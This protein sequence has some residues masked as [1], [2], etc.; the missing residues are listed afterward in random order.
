M[1]ERKKPQK[2]AR[3]RNLLRF[4]LE[5][6][7]DEPSGLQVR[8]DDTAGPYSRNAAAATGTL[9]RKSSRLFQRS[10]A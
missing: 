4:D 10:E 3:A 1:W 2:W 7:A 6:V 8:G 5:E 9:A